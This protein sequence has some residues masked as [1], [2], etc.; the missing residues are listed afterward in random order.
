MHFYFNITF[1]TRYNE[2]VLVLEILD[3]RQIIKSTLVI[4]LLYLYSF[5]VLYQNLFSDN[6]CMFDL[7]KAFDILT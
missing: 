3:I 5:L 6:Y 4:L 2:N 7:N 1:Y